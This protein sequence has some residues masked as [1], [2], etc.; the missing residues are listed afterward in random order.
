MNQG[1]SKQ[2]ILRGSIAIGIVAIIFIVQTDWFRSLFNKEPLSKIDPNATV[3]DIVT[4]DTNGNGVPDWEEKLWGLDPNVLYTNGVSNKQLIEEKKRALGITDTE[5]N[6]PENDTDK[7]A[8][9]IYALT[10]AL[11]QSEEV[12]QQTLT[13]IAA[14][15]S[16]SVDT[17]EPRAQ[18]SVKDLKTVPTTTASLNAYYTAMTRLA[19]TYAD[20]TSEMEILIAAL[21]KGD[22]SRLPELSEDAQLYSQYAK[23]MKNIPVPIVL[24]LQH[25]K[26]FNA[27]AGISTTLPSLTEFDDNAIASL[28]GI[29]LFRQY[30]M[31]LDAATN[32]IREYLTKY[33]IL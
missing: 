3:G 33:G 32:E 30:S 12:D 1:P 20:K 15:I 17:K 9:E 4:K 18:Y 25:L 13:R 2:F 8:R 22:T 29:A 26:L 21:D 7:L 14:K 19:E 27:V 23:D 24:Q 31:H 10:L 5:S 6:E 16:E 11:G 28:V